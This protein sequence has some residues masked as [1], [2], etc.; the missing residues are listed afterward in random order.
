MSWDNILDEIKE[1]K[2][3]GPTTDNE[4]T[5][6]Q[7]PEQPTQVPAATIPE[8]KWY[9]VADWFTNQDELLKAIL[10]QLRT[11]ST[12]IPTL[13][14]PVPEIPQI[15]AGI[16]PKLDV[17]AR[18]Q[19]RT[20][21]LLEGFNFL[22]GQGSVTTPGTPYELVS[23]VKTYLIIIRAN[24]GNI[25]SIFIG[26]RGVSATTGYILDPGEALAIQIDNLKKSVWIDS[27]SANDGVSWIA[28][29]D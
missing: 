20:K 26:G 16:E 2:N 25:S 21:E 3:S 29:V 28:L 5:K 11:I 17:I 14:P 15:P 10:E 24:I 13:I 22:T 1:I 7:S 12:L 8:P 19:T 6:E 18:E 23:T 9:Q 4:E 27:V